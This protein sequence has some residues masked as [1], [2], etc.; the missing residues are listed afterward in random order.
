MRGALLVHV[1]GG[2]GEGVSDVAHSAGVV[3]VDVG[4]DDAGQVVGGDP[5]VVE[6][7]SKDGTDVWLPVST[8]T[9]A[10]PVIR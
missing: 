10:G 1:D 6:G 8:S 2:V 9:G 7:R 3:E 4:D 5:E